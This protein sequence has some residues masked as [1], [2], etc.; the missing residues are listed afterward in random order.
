M[1]KILLS[2]ALLFSVS[3]VVYLIYL[4]E[5]ILPQKIKTAVVSGLVRTTGK[6]VALNT[7]RLDI[8]RGL[9]IKDLSISDEKGEILAV[10]DIS[11]RFLIIPILKKEIIITSLKLN[12]PKLLLERQADNSINII[13]LFLKNKL[14]FMDGKFNLRILRIVVSG[15]FIN[16]K[17]YTLSPPYEKNITDAYIDVKISLPDKINFNSDFRL[18]SEMPALVKLSGEY[19]IL[20]KRFTADIE[21]KDMYPKDFARYLEG[22]KVIIPEGRIDAL[23]RLDLNKNI[24]E[25]D[26]DTSGMD[27]KFSDGKINAALS[28]AL[29]AKIKSDIDTKEIIYRGQMNVKNLALANLEFVNNIYDIRGNLDFSEK[30]F[31]FNNITATVFGLPVK[32]TAILKDVNNP[33]LTIDANTE[34]ELSSLKNLLTDKF[35]IP[36]PFD[37]IGKGGLELKLEYKMSDITVPS[38]VNGSLLMKHAEIKSEYGKEPLKDVTGK[39]QFTQNQLD[40][41]DISF[42]YIDTGYRASGVVTNFD[43]PGVQLE[44]NSDK[45]YAETLFAVSNKTIIISNL[46]GSYGDYDFSAQGELDMTD[47][48]NTKVD[49]NGELKFELSEQKEPFVKFKDRFKD[50]KPSGKVVTLF[51]LKGSINDPRACI[52]DAEIKSNSLSIYGFKLSEFDMMCS[53]R[54]GIIDIRYFNSLLYG[55]TLEGTG[56]IDTVSKGTPYQINADLRG[57]KIEALKKDT[58]FRNNDITGRIQ[59]YVG[60]KGYSSDFDRLSAWGKISIFNGNLWQLNLFRGIGTILFKSDFSSVVFKE[61]LC[62]FVVQ[63]KNFITNNLVMKSD[64]LNIYGSVKLSFDKSISAS[65]KAEFTDEGIDAGNVSNIAGAIERY[66]ILDVTGTLNEPKFKIRPDLTNVLTD[67]ADNFLQ[68]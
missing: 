53:Q 60:V 24:L 8:F 13:D 29:K 23:I 20:A 18:P 48:A 43:S 3:A 6:K 37:M 55:G 16:F 19:K 47:A 58:A 21:A 30:G 61:G 32:A 31:I 22:Y 45:L 57:I 59:A 36:M 34:V 39:F 62:D 15:G 52:I 63:D 11:L 9:V 65:L 46:T 50:L 7:A 25:A 1:K 51:S 28:A 54:N 26:V 10:K 41:S 49:V 14:S 17:D 66:M 56:I 4:N 38:A 44:L 2:I 68:R 42:K 5:V 40:F 67:I 33:I 12:S 64:L 35:N 27:L